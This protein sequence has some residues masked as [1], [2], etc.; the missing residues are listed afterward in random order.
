MNIILN[1]VIKIFLRSNPS[2]KPKAKKPDEVIYNKEDI[3]VLKG[4]A[5]QSDNNEK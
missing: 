2:V 4:E 3:I 1:K 5:K